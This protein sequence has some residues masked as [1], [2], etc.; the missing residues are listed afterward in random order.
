MGTAGYQFGRNISLIVANQTSARD[1]STLHIRFSVRASDTETPNTLEVR[2]FNVSPTTLAEILSEYTGVILQAGYQD[3]IAT[4]FKGT[5]K[6]FRQGKERNTDNFLDIIAADGDEIYNFGFVNTT[7][8]RGSSYAE[9]FNAICTSLGAPQ[10]PNATGYLKSTGGVLP[11]GKVLFGL[12]RTYLRDLA[13]STSTRWSIQNGQI[14]L[15][16]LTGYLPS[17]PV[18]INSQTGMVGVPEATDNG[19]EVEIL[20]NP[21]IQVGQQVQLQ[22]KDIVQTIIREQGYPNYTSLN[23]VASIPAGLG[24][25]RV[26]VVEHDGD[27]R[28]NSPWYS[29]LT[30]L[31]V[32]PSAPPD[33]SVL[34]YGG[35]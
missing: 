22:S 1:L 31:A 17:N 35:G 28:E 33:Q 34:P 5:I 21:L 26:M 9:R 6:Q 27:N 10:D 20:L 12:G 16:P 13:R 30:C 32:D 14:T 4:I 25:Y 18:Q 11:R 2:V 24:T 23:Y 3:Q 15:I 7:V 19:V 8:A 29:R